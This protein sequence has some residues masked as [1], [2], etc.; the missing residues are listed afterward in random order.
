M[1][2]R[3]G[4]RADVRSVDDITPGLELL[5][6]HGWLKVDPGRV[7]PSGGRPSDL[8]TLHPE[9]TKPPRKRAENQVLSVLSPFLVERKLRISAKW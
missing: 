3:A 8:I 2:R 1:H 4:G 5:E 7:G 9:L 6:R